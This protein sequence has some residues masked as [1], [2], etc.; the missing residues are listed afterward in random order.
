MALKD[1]L[2]WKKKEPAKEAV[3][4]QPEEPAATPATQSREDFLKANYRKS[5]EVAAEINRLRSHLPDIMKEKNL[6]QLKAVNEQLEHI[7]TALKGA[8]IATAD[9]K[10]ND[11]RAVGVIRKLDCLLADPGYAPERD[12]GLT[13]LQEALAEDWFRID[14]MESVLRK[15]ALIEALEDKVIAQIEELKLAAEIDAEK[16]KL[17]VLVDS[18]EANADDQV[19]NAEIMMLK[20]NIE[21]KKQRLML[22]RNER[23]NNL[24]M[25]N[26]VKE[27]LK[28]RLSPGTSAF[29]DVYASIEK[30]QEK[31]RAVAIERIRQLKEKLISEKVKLEMANEA[32]IREGVVVSVRDM[33]ENRDMLTEKT[34]ETG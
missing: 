32:M 16:A 8:K 2:P 24:E 14:G 18:Y 12:E 1:L 33:Q 19:L 34:A 25:Y 20:N 7:E 11:T 9:L 27:Q 23:I 6:D 26:L 15:L 31:Q 30:E 10:D 13:R 21:R 4:V 5:Q 29:A 17:S 28:S 22:V 3:T